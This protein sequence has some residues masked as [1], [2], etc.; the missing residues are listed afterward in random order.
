MHRKTQG[1]GNLE[2]ESVVPGLWYHDVSWLR[3][4]LDWR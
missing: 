1:T 3:V 2:L 4:V